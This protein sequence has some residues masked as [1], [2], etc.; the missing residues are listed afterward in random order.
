MS[1]LKLY[2]HQEK[3]LRELPN[4]HLLSWSCGTG[5]T[6]TAI[7]WADKKCEITLVICPKS[8]V[9]NWYRE[10]EKWSDGRCKFI[11][12]SKDQFRLRWTL[13]LE[14]IDG[15]ILDEAHNFSGY[16]SQLYKGVLS[17]ISKLG[18]Q[19]ILLLTATPYR[20]TPFNIF[21]LGNILGK[22][23]NW[24]KFNNTFFTMIKRGPRKWPVLKSN[25]DGVPVK[26][27]I[28]NMVKSLG[29][30]VAMSDVVDV[31]EHV[32]IREDFVINAEQKKACSELL[33]STAIARLSKVFQILN[34][35]LKSDGYSE[36]KYF[37]C[38]K[39]DR[40]LELIEENDKI[41]VICR[42][43]LE[44]Y[45]FRDSIKDRRVFILNGETPK[46]ERDKLIQEFNNSDKC[47]IL[48]QA[49]VCEGYNLYTPVMMFYSMD[50]GLVEWTQMIGRPVRL[51]N[52]KSVVYINLVYKDTVDNAVYEN[53]VIKKQE[54]NAE[55]YNKNI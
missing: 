51:D 11:I 6:A 32:W 25:I 15:L 52:L 22:N 8:L 24:F 5:K 44:L 39:F 20:S 14:T 4:K 27:Y 34:G 53:V 47:V 17:F 29:S 26:E 18:I 9:D 33:D 38:E 45:R 42:H 37:K 13:I 23:W 1:N 35:S 21:C 30:V 36:D 55:I 54:F 3:I 19:N 16:K 48:I 49:K 2:P 28:G 31:P 41:A 40:S 10:I 43:S 7:K 46:E 12:I 50:W